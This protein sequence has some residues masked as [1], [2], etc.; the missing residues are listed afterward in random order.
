MQVSATIYAN[1][2]RRYAVAIS[3]IALLSTVAF[4]FL[5]LALQESEATALVVNISGKQRML[6]QRIASLSQQVGTEGASSQ[7]ILREQLQRAIEEMGRANIA[8]SSG[9]LAE[10][11]KV[12]LSAAMN[13]FYFGPYRLKE[14]VEAY[15]AIAAEVLQT[16]DP[17]IRKMLIDELFEHSNLLLGDPHA[18]VEQYQKEGERNITRIRHLES[19]AWILTLLTLMLEVIFIFQPMAIKIQQLYAELTHHREHL[20]QEIALRTLSLEQAN[21]KLANLASHDPLTGLKNRLTFETALEALLHHY[22]KGHPGFGLLMLDIDY[23][24]QINDTYGHTIGDAVL[25]ELATL[26][27]QSVRD[28]DDVYRL[29]GEEFMILFQRIELSALQVKSSTLIEAVAA[30]TFLSDSYGLHVTISGGLYHP[31]LADASSVHELLARTDTALY[32]SKRNGRN[33][34]SMVDKRS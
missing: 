23:F 10:G 27:R 2:T 8:L 11:H 3:L 25:Q 21:A 16:N 5:Y 14:R 17:D 29:G 24:K 32:A 18:A 31:D 28:G 33:R 15:L 12:T 22:A 30:H 9:R 34:L 13:A 7:Q 1:I 20:E 4:Y 6:S 26:L 19:T